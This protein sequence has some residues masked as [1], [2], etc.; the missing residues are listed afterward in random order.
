MAQPVMQTSFAAGEFSTS[1]YAR[2]DLAKY[3]AGAALLR[4][5]FVDYR[6]G[7]SNRAGTAI[8]G[9]AK[10][11]GHPVRLIKSTFNVSQSYALEFGHQYMRV[12]RNGAY[13]TEATFALTAFTNANPGVATTGA[14]H[15]FAVGDQVYLA[16]MQG[17]TALNGRVFII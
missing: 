16:G 17:M 2:V 9:V 10:D 8:V 14:N 15:N 11:S 12:I 3:H 5:F 6:G 13:V 1:L 7:A 4:N